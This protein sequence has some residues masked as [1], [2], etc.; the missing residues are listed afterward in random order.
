MPMGMSRANLNCERSLLRSIFIF[1]DRQ[2]PLV[3]VLIITA[4]KE[5]VRRSSIQ[6]D[7]SM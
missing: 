3:A 4:A 6:S 2:Q 7:D 5:D 1:L